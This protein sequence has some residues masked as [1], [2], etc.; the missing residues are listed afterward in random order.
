MSS[1]LTP[2]IVLITRPTELEGLIARHGTRNQAEF[3]L[4]SRGQEMGDVLQRARRFQTALDLLLA[5]VPTDWRLT[6]VDR[7]DL[8]RF[9]FDP[10]DLVVALGQDGLVANL[11]KYLNG[12]AVLGFDPEPGQNAGVLVR[13]DAKDA[14]E[15]FRATVAKR[16][17]IQARAMVEA[18]VEVGP[19]LLALNEIFVGHQS[20]QS[21][22]YELQWDGRSERQS[23]SGLIVST[24]TGATGWTASIV[25]ERAEAMELPSPGDPS[26]AFFVREAWP[27]AQYGVSLTAGTLERGNR[28]RIVS[29]MDRGVLFGDGIES[30][31]ISLSWGQPIEIGLAEEQLH[32][33]TG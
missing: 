20:H 29:H 31:R 12:Q 33:V 16:V 24:G 10:G 7:A 2:R 13:F 14:G 25:R 11:A 17:H 22:R 8:D 4:R 32:L 26:L 9:L 23:S 3:F 6:R 30:D 15:L 21:A 28:L 27:G 18:Q 19:R 1:T 5:G